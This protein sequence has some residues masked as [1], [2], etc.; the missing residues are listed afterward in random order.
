[1][2]E[3]I[4]TPRNIPSLWNTTH[5]VPPE[6]LD[7]AQKAIL[8]NLF[9]RQFKEN[10]KG[11]FMKSLALNRTKSVIN[12]LAPAL[13]LLKMKISFQNKNPICQEF[14]FCFFKAVLPLS[15]NVLKAHLTKLP[16]Y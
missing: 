1:M 10:F 12:Y 6:T 15:G 8:L 16:L 3:E 5:S 13:S 14:S 4:K 11:A 2:N 7:I 9:L